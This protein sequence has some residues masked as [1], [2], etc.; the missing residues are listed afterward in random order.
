MSWREIDLGAW[1]RRREAKAAAQLSPHVDAMANAIRHL[2]EEQF[3]REKKITELTDRYYSGLVSADAI[4][5]DAITAG[6][7]QADSL[8]ILRP[9]YFVTI[10]NPDPEAPRLDVKGN[11]WDS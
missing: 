6:R 9:D 1:R 8:S 5:A 3:A 11:I 7:I 4:R 2:R 10:H